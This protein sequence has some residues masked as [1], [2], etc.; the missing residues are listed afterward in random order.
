MTAASL[1]ALQLALV[2]LW[3]KRPSYPHLV[4]SVSLAAACVSFA[5]SVMSCALSYLEHVKSLRPSALLNVFWLLSLLLDCALLRS[6][7]LSKLLDGDTAIRA[8]FSAAFA[9][10]AA[11]VLLEAQGKTQHLLARAR[12]VAPEETAGIYARAALA[13][14][15]PL[16]RT[17][18]QRLLRPDDMCAL[19]EE[20]STEMLNQKFWSHWK[21]C[22]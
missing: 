1:A 14:V 10:K 16:L 7:W 9:V 11:L 21:K 3:A 12:A 5:S 22:K 4:S 20:M 6:L 19:D 8:V 2:V 15:A 13:W 18:F 17:G